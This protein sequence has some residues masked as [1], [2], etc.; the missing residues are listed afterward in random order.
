MAR[1]KLGNIQFN[2]RL[3][4]EVLAEARK[5]ADKKEIRLGELVEEALRIYLARRRGK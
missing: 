4:P 2:V 3:K 1:A 5:Y